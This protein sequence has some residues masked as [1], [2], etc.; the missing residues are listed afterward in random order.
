MFQNV[1]TSSRPVQPHDR[2]TERRGFLAIALAASFL[3]VLAGIG[4]AMDYAAAASTRSAIAAIVDTAAA[5]GVE[6]STLQRATE[7][8]DGARE[9]AITNVVLGDL[10]DRLG[11]NP[12]LNALVRGASVATKIAGDSVTTDVCVRAAT[13]TMIMT[14][15]GVP[16]L[17]TESCG[18]AVGLLP[19]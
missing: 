5:G 2:P 8:A 1:P 15:F 19:S 11:G 14:V 7:T 3:P 16:A 18:R 6:A 13:R 10:F 12:S 9:R 4:S 17:E